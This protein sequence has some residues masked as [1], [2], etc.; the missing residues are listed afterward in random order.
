MILMMKI[1]ET[2]HL[3]HQENNAIDQID[4]QLLCLQKNDASV[5]DASFLIYQASSSTTLDT[6]TA[7]APGP[8]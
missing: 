3:V 4:Y 5:K 6:A 7:S 2:K 1:P 8:I